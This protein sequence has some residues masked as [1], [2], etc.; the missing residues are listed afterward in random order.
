VS[1]IPRVALALGL[2]AAGFA[3]A[4]PA[5]AA[6]PP[7]ALTVAVDRTYQALQ[8]GRTLVFNSTIANRGTRPLRDLIAHL[9]VL[10]LRRGVYVDPEDWS[11]SRTRYLGTLAAGASVRVAWRVQAVDAGRFALYVA[12]LPRDVAGAAPATGP[13]IVVA[14]PE[15]QT[16]DAGGIAPLA[17]GIP[18]VLGLATVGLRLRRR[19]AR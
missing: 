1:R 15:R 18:A 10:S 9:N 7:P 13:A 2:L 14:V 3:G 8:L 6:S 11:T 17:I 4:L 19:R 16:L 5:R 12:A